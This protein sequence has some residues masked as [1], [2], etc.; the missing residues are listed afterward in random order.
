MKQ[1]QKRALR[2]FI[3][4]SLLIALMAGVNLYLYFIEG[5]LMSLAVAVLSGIAFIGWVYFYK[6]YVRVKE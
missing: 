2:I 1:E 4:F 5:N 3:Q 6:R